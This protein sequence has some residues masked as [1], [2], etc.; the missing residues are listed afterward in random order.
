VFGRT[1]LAAR[2]LSRGVKYIG[3]RAVVLASSSRIL[4]AIRQEMLIFGE[5]PNV[6]I[7]AAGS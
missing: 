6:R 7:A 5:E 4:H 3:A 1:A 2:R